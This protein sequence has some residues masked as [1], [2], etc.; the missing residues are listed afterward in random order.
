MTPSEDASQ[1]STPPEPRPHTLAGDIRLHPAFHSRYLCARDVAVYL[2]PGYDPVEATRY[3]VLYLA[4]GQNL[5]DQA[6]A[7]GDEWHVD[8]TAQSLITAGTIQ[9]LIIVGIHSAKE[10]RLDEFTPTPRADQ[11]G[12][13]F[14]DDYG[15]MLIEEIKPFI[16]AHYNTLPSAASTGFGGSS[17]GALLA[18]RLGV[19][20]PTA[21]GKLA[22][23][24][25]SIWWD[26]RVILR[27]VE[28]LAHKQ[29]QRVWLDIGTAEGDEM[30]GDARRLRDV[31]VSKGWTEGDDL[32][33]R[34]IDGGGHDE[35]SWGARI[36]DVLAFL[37]PPR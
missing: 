9:P 1:Q 17:L 27:E 5:F 18:L 22:L 25:P 4:D 6:T 7:F 24:S 26:D 33:Y 10:R 14:A 23:L 20:Y 30:L 28:S 37:H 21:I 29:P 11:G 2:P 31:L 32:S 8:E 16:D 15:R 3:P 36:G 34:E 35:K 12:G 19:R 13:G